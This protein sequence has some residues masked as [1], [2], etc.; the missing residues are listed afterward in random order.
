MLSFVSALEAQKMKQAGWQLEQLVE[1]CE[2][3]VMGTLGC[4]ALRARELRRKWCESRSSE[5]VFQLAS[6]MA[7]TERLATGFDGLDEALGGGVRRG[8][9]TEVAGRAGS[10]KSQWCTQLAAHCA[11]STGAVVYI[12]TEGSFRADRLTQI[13]KERRWVATKT[14]TKDMLERVYVLRPPTAEALL[15]LL[16]G[17]VQKQIQETE[18]VLVILDSVAA[19]ARGDFIGRKI[20]D[21]QA[22]LAA[23]AAALK[24]LAHRQNVAVLVTNHVVADFGHHGDR[25]NPAL[26]LLW[27][28]CVTTRCFFLRNDNNNNQEAPPDD[29][30]N[31][32]GLPASKRKRIYRQT[33][34]ATVEKAPDLPKT[35]V[36]YC[37]EA[38]GL[39]NNSRQEEEEDDGEEFYYDENNKKRQLLEPAEQ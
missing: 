15:A 33:G 27:S 24:A 5:L 10:G 39:V 26:G 9:L 17:S 7:R 38:G 1:K 30:Q 36:S 28:H 25:V 3:Q 34:I 31:S 12:D 14:E 35:T 8:G 20:F 23:A 22:W 11:S 16:H 4:S 37:I 2:T 6:Q 19:L 29:D 21:R 32:G 13:A 18:A